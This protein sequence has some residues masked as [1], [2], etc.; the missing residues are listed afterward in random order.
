LITYRTN[1]DVTNSVIR[2]QLVHYQVDPGLYLGPGLY[3]RFYG[4]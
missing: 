4:K 2:C 3:L 1:Y